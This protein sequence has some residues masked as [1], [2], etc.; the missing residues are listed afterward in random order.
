VEIALGLTCVLPMLETIQSL[1]KLVQNEE[2]FICDFVEVVKFIQVDLYTLYVDP[3]RHIF[4]DQFQK[5]GALVGT[6]YDALPIV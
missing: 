3:K 6:S 2:C 4:C 1:N 5:F